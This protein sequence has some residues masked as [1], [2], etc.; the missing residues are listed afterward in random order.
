MEEKSEIENENRSILNFVSLF[1]GSKN[2]LLSQSLNF[3][4]AEVMRPLG[5]SVFLLLYTA[6]II[7]ISTKAPAN[8]ILQISSMGWFML[9]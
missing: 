8:E 3:T 4:A 7:C 5:G 1:L 2:N 9:I 6:C